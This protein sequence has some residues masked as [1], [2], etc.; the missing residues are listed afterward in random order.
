MQNV[1]TYPSETPTASGISEKFENLIGNFKTSEHD[2]FVQWRE[3]LSEQISSEPA[4]VFNNQ[5]C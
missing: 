4:A 5:E 3:K 1:C 2:L